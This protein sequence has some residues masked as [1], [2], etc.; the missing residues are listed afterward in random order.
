M[1][2]SWGK[3]TIKVTAIAESGATTPGDIPT[4]VEDSSELST[5][6]GDKKEATI[7]GGEAEA[8]KYMASKST[9]VFKI[10][11]GKGRT[12]PIDGVD[13]VVKGEFKVELTPED[14]S[15]PGFVM[16]RAVCSYEDSYTAADGLIRTYTFDSLKP[17]TGA[18]VTFTTGTTGGA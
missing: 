14:A 1:I 17:D 3:P 13:G 12:L 16:N 8:V 2:I 11:H 10:R 9:F 18:Q 4:P 7:E 6:K 15:A 5:E